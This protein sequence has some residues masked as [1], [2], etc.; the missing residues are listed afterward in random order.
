MPGSG[1]QETQQDTTKPILHKAMTFR[2]LWVAQSIKR[3]PSAQ[4]MIL[5]SWNRVSCRAPCSAGSLLLFLP[6]LLVFLLSLSFS[7]T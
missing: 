4:V 6:F 5:G 7:N 3:L 2:G 1:E